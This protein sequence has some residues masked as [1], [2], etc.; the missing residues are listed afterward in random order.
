MALIV[1]NTPGTDM[2]IS[3]DKVKGYKHFSNKLWNIARFIL[4][5]TADADRA[6]AYTEADAA[7]MH[8]CN[9]VAQ[10]VTTDIEEYRVHL[11][12]EKLYHYVWHELA[13]QILEA[14]KPILTGEDTAASASRKRLLLAILDRSLRL[15]HPFM[16]FVT[17]EIWQSLPS[18]DAAFLMIARWPSTSTV[19]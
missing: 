16:P 10:D 5:N 6:A 4:E 15:L 1:G 18:K 19:E 14:S 3:E 8:A 13:D 17:E 9:H 11:A 2:R 7:L 12:A